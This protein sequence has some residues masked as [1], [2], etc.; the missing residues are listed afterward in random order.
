MRAKDGNSENARQTNRSRAKTLI[1]GDKLEKAE[2]PGFS[3]HVP[4]DSDSQDGLARQRRKTIWKYDTLQSSCKSTID[5]Y[6][7]MVGLQCGCWWQ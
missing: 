2:T 4:E 6:G 3:L 1:C 7:Q 5:T